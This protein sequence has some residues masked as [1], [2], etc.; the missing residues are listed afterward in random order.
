MR[1]ALGVPGLVV[2][3]GAA[4]AALAGLPRPHAIFIG[5]GGSDDGVLDAAIDALGSGGRLVANAVT[6][7]MEAI[8]LDRHA[9]LGGELM[10]IAVSRAAPVGSMQG[11]RPAMPVTQWSWVKP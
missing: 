8:L 9:R 7:E 10:R 5:G 4:P 11:W 3:E 1:L 2:V 6:L